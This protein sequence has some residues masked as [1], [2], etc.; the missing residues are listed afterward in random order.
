MW[1]TFL[2]EE[3]WKVGGTEEK[4]KETKNETKNDDRSCTYFLGESKDS[5]QRRDY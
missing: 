3:T 1:K 5:Q 4:Y 2:R